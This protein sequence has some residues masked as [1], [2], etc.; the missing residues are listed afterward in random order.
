MISYKFDCGCELPIL[1]SDIKDCD[2][3]PSLGIDFYN[4]PDC[5]ETWELFHTGRTKGIWQ[6]E[7]NL[8][9]Q[10]SASMKPNNIEELSALI[11]TIRPGCL[12]S[13]QE[14]T[15]SNGKVIKR[16]MTQV[17][18]DRK[19]GLEP[20]T[21]FHP[22]LEPILKDT[23][24]IIVYQEQTIRIAKELVGFSLQEAD[25]LRKAMGKK[26][27]KLM[28]ELETLFLSKAKDFGVIT[29][30]EAKTIFAWIKESNRYSFNK[31]H[32]IFYAEL[33]YQSAF[34]KHHFPLH[35]YV[36]WIHHRK[37]T[38]DENEAE[39]LVNDAK[40]FDIQVGLP[41]LLNFHDADP[42]LTILKKHNVYM[43]VN[44]IRGFGESSV[45]TFIAKVETLE[46]TLGRIETWSWMTYLVHLL[47]ATSSRVVNGLI[48]SGALNHTNK[49]RTEML[50]EYN[51][52]R[53]LTN[54]QVKILQEYNFPNLE[55]ALV[56]L[57]SH[58]KTRNLDKIQ[59]LLKSYRQ[60]AY[61]LK[62]GIKV[63]A[64][65]EQEYLGIPIS[66]T[67]LDAREFIGGDTT[68]LEFVNGKNSQI[69]NIAVEITSARE[70]IIKNGK[71]TGRTM[72]FINVTDGTAALNVVAFAE[73]WEKNKEL[74]YKGSTLL[75]SGKR[76]NKGSFQIEKVRQI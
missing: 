75:I 68:C 50:F 64:D 59:N 36:S 1:D 61:S 42:C 41:T 27:A 30:E 67:R 74:F 63:I 62:D 11:S 72:G 69:M 31:S 53:E 17:F 22:S 76:S 52:F 16:S 38:K 32:G 14:T 65:M 46:Q 37:D 56:F 70:N 28:N 45:D 25:Q 39:L 33:G 40:L 34:V 66:C 5:Q 43:G 48:S 26:D 47:S 21:Y 8:G 57:L 4:L 51:I 35:F 2:G 71:S 3:L 10:W 55:E 7:N 13:I 9:Q 20:V 12:N 54:G 44:D 60:P 58:K 6:L 24:G 23:Y 19:N 15:D 73:M 18:S 29:E 49:A